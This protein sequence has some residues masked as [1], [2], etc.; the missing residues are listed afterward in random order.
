MNNKP[1]ITFRYETFESKPALPGTPL[2][3]EYDKI[4]NLKDTDY[5]RFRFSQVVDHMIYYYQTVRNTDETLSIEP[6]TSDNDNNYI[7][8]IAVAYHPN[9]WT[10]APNGVRDPTKFSV[11]EYINQTYLKD[12]Q[13]KKALLLLD[14]SVEG[15]GATWL[16]KWFH[17][18]CEQY[19][20]D[21][22]VII[23]LTG[24][25]SCDE[26]YE[27]WCKENNPTSKLK[28]LP[29]TSLSMY[30]HKHYHRY[31]LNVNVD[32]FIE[33]KKLNSDKIY[34]YDCI[35]LRPRPQRVLNFLHLLNAGLLDYGNIS[36]QEQDK[37]KDH[38]D[39]NVTNFL[40]EYGLPSDILSKLDSSMTPRV[41]QHSKK[42]NS[43][44]YYELVERVLDDMY[45]NSWVSIVTESSY[46]ER[47]HAVFIGEKTFKPIAAAQP[48]IIVGSKHSLKY[49]RKL[50]YKTFHPY[51]DESYDDLDDAERFIAIM[52]A[53]K[54]IQAIEDK[55]AWY[56]SMKDIV[57]HNH[58]L[59][60]SIDTRKSQEHKAIIKYY[61]NMFGDKSV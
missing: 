11:F 56:E 4:G 54:K 12:L 9:D 28:V 19:N 40:T 3:L 32:E 24:D 36:M 23:Y 38:V 59:F 29:S 42:P 2:H 53:I 6:M 45:K 18:K 33:Y 46:F 57:E 1:T 39:L 27:N 50:G 31:K 51:I 5:S 37:W 14:Q 61:F 47:E 55:G 22:S 26:S 30:I 43:D 49:L 21:P 17:N 44:H 48:F 16:W 8:P 34:L 60:L 10:D 20:I 25:Q 15:Y 41:T 7:I 35:N 13:S 58:K 52:N